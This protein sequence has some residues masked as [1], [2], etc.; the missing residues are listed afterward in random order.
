VHIQPGAATAV[1]LLA[2]VSDIYGAKLKFKASDGAT[3]SPTVVLDT[4]QVYAGGA[5]ALFGT[6]PQQ[7]KLTNGGSVDAHVTVFVARDAI[8]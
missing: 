6:A 1:R 7:L 4:P 3:D 8:V 2:I 5:A